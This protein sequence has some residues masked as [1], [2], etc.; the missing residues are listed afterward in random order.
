MCSDTLSLLKEIRTPDE[1]AF[2]K[3]LKPDLMFLIV[4]KKQCQTLT[5]VNTGT[6]FGAAS[7]LTSASAKTVWY[8]FLKCWKTIYTGFPDYMLKDQG[9]LFISAD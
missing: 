2:N 5:T 8:A 6:K 9:S 1:I 7:F 3:E 4:G